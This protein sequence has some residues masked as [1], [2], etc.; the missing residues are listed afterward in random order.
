MTKRKLPWDLKQPTTKRRAPPSTPQTIDLTGDDDSP[1]PS[2][3]SIQKSSSFGPSQHLGPLPTPPSSSQSGYPTSSQRAPQ[4]YKDSTP[5]LSQLTKGSHNA[6]QDQE[7]DIAREIDLTEDFDDDVYENYMLYGILN[8]KIVGCRFYD[9]QATVGEYVRVKREPG[10]PYDTN[11]FRIDNVLRDQ[12]GHIGRKEAA[13]LASL[14]D[15]GS[16]LI[17]GALTGPKTYYDCPIGLK[18]FGTNDPVAGAALAKQMQEQRLPIGEWVRMK[19]EAEKRRQELEKQQK[20]R[21]R[22]A[23]AMQKQGTQVVD[24][25][26]P[27]RYSNLGAASAVSTQ[28][29]VNMD[30]LLSGTS[31][32]NPRD[33]QDAMKKLGSGEDTL[34]KMPMADQPPELATILLPYQRQGLQWMLDH[35][36]PKLPE[37]SD[38]LVQMWKKSGKYYLNIA[39]NFTVCQAPV[40]ASGGLLAD[41]MGLGKTIQVISLVVADPHKDGNPTLII[42]PL[43][44]M[45]N[46]SNQAAFHVKK[47]FAPRILIYHG[48]ENKNLSPQELKEYD[49]VIT[50]Y[51]T[52]TQELFPYGKSTPQPLPASKGLFSIT[53]KF[54]LSLETDPFSQKLFYCPVNNG[55]Y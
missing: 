53:C 51:Q 21:E 3:S 12:I 20:A 17:E 45:S 32:F 54:P 34:E 8:T 52:M 37:K 36:S 19:R 25:E 33:V 27:N 15:S 49:V 48:P 47:K 22:A 11:A 10:N 26:G 5:S 39:T 23:A 55:T 43:S 29:E 31:T 1:S 2:I 35:E 16:L 4:I 42:A 18:L 41:D 7:A 9:G 24:N 6:T 13:K 30:Q 50:T 44:V 38:D 14:I 40:L 28:P 46:W